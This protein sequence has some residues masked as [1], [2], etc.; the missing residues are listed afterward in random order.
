MELVKVEKAELLSILKVNRTAHRAVFEEA[1]KGYRKEAI[2][3][4][5]KALKDAREGRTIT[6]YIRLDA[7]IDQTEDYDRAIRMIGMSVDENIE[8]SEDD[9][10]N[11][12]LDQ[13]HWRQK[14]DAT[15]AF[16]TA[17]EA[18]VR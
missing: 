11:Y 17:T 14:F 13:W 6:T 4:L 3:L 5:D 16:Y 1:Q 12:I 10:R 7:P 9:F 8:I 2:R 18:V 15:N